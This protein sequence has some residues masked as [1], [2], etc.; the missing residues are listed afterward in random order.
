MG[1]TVK[2]YT[3]SLALVRI[4]QP[5]SILTAGD[6]A[7]IPSNVGYLTWD[8]TNGNGSYVAPGLYFYVVNGPT[9][10]T[11]GKFAISKSIYGP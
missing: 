7:Y 8:G 9:G 6:G 1:S 2:I 10:N 11:F 5:S 4:F 3:V